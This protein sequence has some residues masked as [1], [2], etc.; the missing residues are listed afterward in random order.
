MSSDIFKSCVFFVDLPGLGPLP[1]PALP[2]PDSAREVSKLLESH[3]GSLSASAAAATHAIL[4]HCQQESWLEL[5]ACAHDRPV[6]VSLVWILACVEEGRLLPVPPGDK[7]SLLRPLPSAALPGAG[8][9]TASLTGFCGAHRCLALALLRCAG[10]SASKAMQVSTTTHLLAT[11]DE[12]SAPST[13]LDVA[14]SHGIA[15]V[16]L[17]WLLRCL[18]GWALANAASGD[19][20]G[21][22]VLEFLQ[23]HAG[24]EVLE[25]S[26]A[27][28]DACDVDEVPA[29]QGVSE[30]DRTPVELDE[31]PASQARCAVAESPCERYEA[32]ARNAASMAA[33]APLDL[34]G[35]PAVQPVKNGPS[36]QLAVAPQTCSLPVAIAEWAELPAA[37]LTRP[38]SCPALPAPAQRSGGRPSLGLRLS[39]A[40]F[41]APRRQGASQ[42]PGEPSVASAAL[43]GLEADV[44]PS[45]DLEPAREDHMDI[46]R[47]EPGP[48][49]A[50]NVQAR[51][52][53][54]VHGHPHLDAADPALSGGTVPPSP[55]SPQ[56]NAQPNAMDGD[57]TPSDL[58][59][60]PAGDGSPSQG[61]SRSPSQGA[62]EA[63]SAALGAPVAAQ[64]R[65]AAGALSDRG[66]AVRGEARHARAAWPGRRRASRGGP[67]PV[68]VGVENIPPP[69]IASPPSQA[70]GACSA[71]VA[72]A[73]P[74]R[75]PPS[76]TPC[77]APAG[78]GEDRGRVLLPVPGDGDAAGDGPARGGGPQGTTAAEG[79]APLDGP[80][81]ALE[82]RP[83]QAQRKQRGPHRA[84]LFSQ[85]ALREGGGRGRSKRARVT[86][87]AADDA[88]GGGDARGEGCGS[89]V[90]GGQPGMPSAP[91]PEPKVSAPAG[92]RVGTKAKRR[93][94]SGVG[95]AAV[96]GDVLPADAKGRR[97]RG[98]PEGEPAVAVQGP[99]VAADGDAD[100]PAARRPPAPR[101]TRGAAARAAA[102]AAPEPATRTPHMCPLPADLPSRPPCAALSGFHSEEQARL[103]AALRSI[104]VQCLPGNA[105]HSW[106][107][108]VTH[109]VAPRFLRT[110][111]VLAGLA[112]GNW[113]VSPDWVWASAEAGA[114]LDPEPFE[115]RGEGGAGIAR[116]WRLRAQAGAD[117][118]FHGLK[119]AIGAMGKPG[120]T[121]HDLRAIVTAGGGRLVPMKSAGQAD[122]VLADKATLSK[123][124]TAEATVVTPDFLVACLMQ[125]GY[126]EM[127]P[128]NPNRTLVRAMGAMK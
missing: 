77:S 98:L 87:E 57:Q 128:A 20:G 111:K 36:S 13:K 21:M 51:E 44:A 107:P 8:A 59:F 103:V 104:K 58:S 26:S 115:L 127:L 84:P 14:R 2:L 76:S 38:S 75:G 114:C 106:S 12:G 68:A 27:G 53:T 100:S 96:P 117:G 25:G 11:W 124:P 54:Q 125:S 47:E 89:G 42:A 16:G 15:V 79:L 45:L 91:L 32:P 50:E 121:R 9:V 119:V 95:A 37:S 56:T 88:R 71:P 101:P 82:A 17:P 46:R 83:R 19:E 30:A 40:R 3:G 52:A 23:V 72:G 110:N 116:H 6:A 80:A 109:V 94:A 102:G 108:R 10:F 65:S 99:A 60:G 35:A 69:S 105:T 97:R 33:A 7:T 34:E 4:R 62:G 18:A 70:P 90:E 43:P 123:G 41:Q 48:V 93:S 78:G 66:Q 122:L 85:L 28:L 74:E 49:L 29:S 126:R 39:Q 86:V 1:V 92:Q 73:L 31:V 118:P 64:P 22:R 113:V 63:D 24:Q 112:A 67:V 120:P 55:P 61:G 81:A 5:E